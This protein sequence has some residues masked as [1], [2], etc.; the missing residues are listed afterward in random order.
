MGVLNYIWILYT[1]NC[2]NMLAVAK[3]IIVTPKAAVWYKF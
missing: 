2:N 3:V 1:E